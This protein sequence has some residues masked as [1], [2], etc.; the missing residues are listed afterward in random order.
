MKENHTPKIGLFVVSLD[1]ER[2]D[3]AK[4]FENEAR[5]MLQARGVEIL[6]KPGLV[7]DTPS[8]VEAAKAAQAAGADAVVFLIG[9]WIL[10]DGVVTAAQQ[11]CIPYAVWGVPEPVSFSS[12][13]A[14]VVHG[15]MC[16]MDMPHKLLYG[17][18]TDE[19]LGAELIAFL[20]A[21]MVKA[22]LKR[23]RFGLIGGRAISAYTTTADFN[24]I[25]ATFG[26]EVDHIDQMVVLERARA[27]PDEE[28]RKAIGLLGGRCDAA[29][30]MLLK[31]AKT[32]LAIEAVKREYSL[33]MASV[34]CLGE[35]I[36]TYSCCCMAVT[37][38]ND[39]GFTMS[40]QGDVNATITMHILRLLGG[41]ASFFGD[42]STVMYRDGEIRTINC[43]AVPTVL[44]ADPESVPWVEQYEYMGAGRG[45]N[46]VFCMK[47]G[48]VTFSYLGRR[49][50]QYQLL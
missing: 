45:V 40:C 44:A 41:G 26:I 24:Q 23:A 43:G 34:K 4:K 15:A 39:A 28:A 49:K 16:E 2:T 31:S 14:N 21:A 32:Y 9:T 27:I 42:I 50:G 37:L 11:L 48:P 19:A 46:P 30:E 22:R 6:N 3:Y 36:N 10:A 29:E 35:F 12:V 38:E 1:G 17:N 8:L 7:M 5:P 20:R 47:G 33:D 18:P 25:K 13:G